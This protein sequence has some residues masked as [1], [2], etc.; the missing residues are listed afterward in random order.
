M[1]PAP[2]RIDGYTR[3]GSDLSKT[4]PELLEQR[5]AAA[6]AELRAAEAE[7]DALRSRQAETLALLLETERRRAAT[8]QRLQEHRA[9]CP[10][11]LT[12]GLCRL[13]RLVRR[14]RGFV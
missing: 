3:A 10:W 7:I 4:R 8:E 5:A 9:S 14:T 13:Q 12:E 1:G 2:A 6:A 11:R